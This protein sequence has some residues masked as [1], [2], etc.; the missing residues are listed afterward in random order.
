MCKPHKHQGVKGRGKVS[1]LV[2]TWRDEAEGYLSEAEQIAEF[3]CDCD[4]NFSEE[5]ACFVAKIS[6]LPG[7]AAHGD[8]CEEALSE[9]REALLLFV[10]NA[11][12]TYFIDRTP[13]W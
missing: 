6:E 1:E 4:C 11:K 8:T 2:G 7:I 9:L 12:L 13:H 3:N 5:D 10:E